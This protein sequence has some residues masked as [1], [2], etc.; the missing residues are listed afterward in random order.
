MLCSNP[1]QQSWICS[2]CGKTGVDVIGTL[3]T[4]KYD[5]VVK[6]FENK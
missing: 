3:S 6:K 1:P 5:E 2:S 4:T